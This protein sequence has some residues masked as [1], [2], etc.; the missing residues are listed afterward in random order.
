MPDERPSDE[1][2]RLIGQYEQHVARAL[3]DYVS[4][5]HGRRLRGDRDGDRLILTF[6]LDDADVFHEH[7][8]GLN[9]G[10]PGPDRSG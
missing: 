6:V 8:N 10:L 5:E 3:L 4:G 7:F 2:A 1:A 9:Q